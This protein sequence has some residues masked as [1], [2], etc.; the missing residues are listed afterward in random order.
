MF[1]H[2]FLHSLV[3]DSIHPCSENDDF[4]LLPYY[5]TLWVYVLTFRKVHFEEV[6]DMLNEQEKLMEHIPATIK[7]TWLMWITSKLIQ[8]L[9][10]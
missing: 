8:Q 10:Q 2:V 4:I 6:R 7:I 3:V 1:S 9:L 5:T